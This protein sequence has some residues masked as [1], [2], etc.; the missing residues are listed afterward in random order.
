MTEPNFG[1]GGISFF[2]SKALKKAGEILQS[3]KKILELLEDAWKLLERV[4]ENKFIKELWNKITAMFRLIKAYSDGSFRDI[5]WNFLLLLVTAIV[6]FVSP[7]DAI[8][9][10]I[11][12]VGFADD[13]SVIAIIYNAIKPIID[14]FIEWEK[15]RR[16]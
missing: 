16:G 15:S 13:A 10:V 9:D 8:P 12:I 2:W 11:P 7:V 14:K 1:N 4:R 6:Y 3:A 5:P